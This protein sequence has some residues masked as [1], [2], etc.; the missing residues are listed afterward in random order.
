MP[1]VSVFR[2]YLLR[3]A[4]LLLAV[5]LGIT[6]WPGIISPSENLSHMGSAVNAFLGAIALLAAV[7]IRYPLKM[8]PLLFFELTWKAIWIFAF[9][10]PLW[11]AG[12]L[13][14]SMR[15]TL[16]DCLVVVVFIPLIPWRYVFK[17]YIKAPG[18]RWHGRAMGA[19]DKGGGGNQ[20]I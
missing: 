9:G 1:E 12:T 18:D 5:A 19:A 15:Q 16:Y 13:E 20:V 8:L 3:A 17:H 11:L 6:I 10:L 4:Y 14:P 7:G 2:L